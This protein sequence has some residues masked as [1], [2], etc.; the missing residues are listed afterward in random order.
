MTADGV[1]LLHWAQALA[2]FKYL[3]YLPACLLCYWLVAR[4]LPPF[5]R[6]IAALALMAKIP[7]VLMSLDTPSEGSFWGFVWHYD[8]EHNLPSTLGYLLLACAGS[9]GLLSAWTGREREGWQRLFLL[10]LGLLL[11]FMSFDEYFEA[12]K[13]FDMAVRTHAWERSYKAIGAVTGLLTLLA[14][15]LSLARDRFWLLA[16]LAG[17]ASMA[18]GGLVI[19]SALPLCGIEGV[20]AVKTCEKPLAIEEI[21]EFLGSWL[22]FA[23]ML[24]LH[25]ALSPSPSTRMRRLVYAL[26]L[27]WLLLIPLN[28]PVGRLDMHAR[29]IPA[30]ARFDGGID[31]LGFKID[32]TQDAVG[33]SLY[34]SARQADYAPLADFH[35]ALVDQASGA[36]NFRYSAGIDHLHGVWFFGTH[37][38]PVYRQPIRFPHRGLPP[39]RAQWITVGLANQSGLLH[40]SASDLRQLNDKQV[41]LGEFV[42]HAPAV[43]APAAPIAAFDGGFALVN[44]DLP[45]A[46]SPGDTLEIAMTWHSDSDASEDY[47]QFLHFFHAESGEQWGH[48]QP[49]LGRSLPTRLWYAGMMDTETWRVLAPLNAAPGEYDVYTGLYRPQDISRLRTYDAAGNAYEHARVHLGTVDIELAAGR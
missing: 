11:L 39:N 17:L 49:P 42:V 5:A 35:I 46:A 18:L 32:T 8:E 12:Y 33:L 24:G 20:F 23:G 2:P 43:D 44:A 7:L 22:V 34:M 28:S 47:T 45:A 9:F 6:R 10:A 13:N 27:M 40:I 37:Y 14:A 16:T 48:D 15:L 1:L 41:I 30:S 25:S 26:P 29:A 4:R 38:R 31:L 36:A 3:V 21:Y 19:D